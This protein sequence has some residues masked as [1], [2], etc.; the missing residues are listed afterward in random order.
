VSG[1]ARFLCARKKEDA[2]QSGIRRL[3]FPVTNR[4]LPDTYEVVAERERFEAIYKAQAGA[5]RSYVR[6]R[7]DA[8][9]AD[10]VVADVFLVVW[11]RLEEVPAEPLPWLLGIARRVLAN[12]RR[13]ETRSEALQNRL[14]NEALVRGADGD[15]EGELATIRA[16]GTLSE[17]DQEL[18]LLVAWEGLSRSQL[19]AA[20][21]LGQGAVRMRLHRARQRFARALAAQDAAVGTDG[22][23]SVLEV[24]T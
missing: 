15:P 2:T 5:I 14:R 9:E 11:R 23:S 17:L 16:L 22:R 20:L 13:A 10:D 3:V 12:R 18:L 6:R 1:G 24:S 7:L 4:A 21:E 19:A 8:S